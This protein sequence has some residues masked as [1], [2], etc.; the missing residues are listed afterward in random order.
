MTPKTLETSI[1]RHQ[2]GT[3][4]NVHLFF[5]GGS[6]QFGKV[7]VQSIPTAH[8][9]AD[10]SAFIICSGKKKLGILT[11]LGHAFSDLDSVIAS[12]DAVFIESNY[13]PKLL[14]KGPYPESLRA[15]I[16]GFSGHLSNIESAELIASYGKRLKWACL[17]HLS[18]NNNNPLLALN[19]HSRVIDPKIRLNT[20]S[21]YVVSEIF[22]V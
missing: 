21:R 15:R 7:T 9:G 5:S 2:L 12:L 19:T 18:E 14:E 16:R 4:N 1:Q 22:S 3:M 10:G 6:L 13:D 8:D 11:D 17:A 20:A